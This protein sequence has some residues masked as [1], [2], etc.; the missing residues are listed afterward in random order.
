ML[1]INIPGYKLSFVKTFNKAGGIDVYIY[2]SLNC[3]VS[4]KFHIA[5]PSCENMWLNVKA[6]DSKSY[7]VGIL[8][9]HPFSTEVVN[10]MEQQNETL[11]HVTSV[12][13]ECV[14]LGNFNIDI[15]KPENSHT[16]FYLNMLYS[17]A[18][19]SVTDKLTR[20]TATSS[21]LLDLN[22]HQRHCIIDYSWY[23]KM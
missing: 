20:I 23:F 10:F 17:N 6:K 9:R 18:L 7:V 22:T 8:Y 3:T 14:I 2:N 5:L 19:H 4:H 16:I 15:L 11:Q 1:N 13:H 21:S 12:G